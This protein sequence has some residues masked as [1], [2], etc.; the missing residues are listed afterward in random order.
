MLLS[1][2]MEW[3]FSQ[4]QTMGVTGDDETF[5]TLE[6]PML[7]E[8]LITDEGIPLSVLTFVQQLCA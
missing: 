4:I 3:I 8:I 5:H 7:S 2:M 6:Y 1:R